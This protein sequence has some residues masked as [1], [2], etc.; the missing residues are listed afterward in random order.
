MLA[1]INWAYRVAVSYTRF[2]PMQ[3]LVI[4]LLALI[5]KF[6]ATLALFLPVKIILLVGNDRT[7]AYFPGF[8]TEMDRNTLI[9]ALCAATIGFYLL[10]ILTEKVMER[11]ES[12]AEKRLGNLIPSFL[13]TKTAME[14]V[15]KSYSR[16]SAGLAELLFFTVVMIF[17]A[18]AYPDLLLVIMA[19]SLL[20][21]GLFEFG[22]LTASRQKVGDEQGSNDEVEASRRIIWF[23]V[24]FLVSFIY[25][26]YD[27]L[28]G[29]GPGILI[30]FISF[31]LIRRSS[32]GLKRI[33]KDIGVLSA[34]R[35]VI[36]PLIFSESFEHSQ[37]SSSKR[38][39]MKKSE[40]QAFSERVLSK[41]LGD[42][43]ASPEVNWLELG[44]RDLMAYRLAL[45]DGGSE[46]TF[47]LTVYRNKRDHRPDRELSLRTLMPQLPAPE[48]IEYGTL[49][50]KVW[51]LS[52]WDDFIDVDSSETSD[53][54]L[55]ESLMSLPPPEPLIE[56]WQQAHPP[57]WQRIDEHFWEEMEKI[58]EML[59]PELLTKISVMKQARSQ[60][61]EM[62]QSLPLTMV[63]K[64]AEEASIKY[65]A[66]G[67]V[68]ALLW[69]KWT[70]EPLGAGWPVADDGLEVLE[71]VLER[72]QQVAEYLQSV[73]PRDIVL[74]ALFYAL[75][76]ALNQQRY[77]ETMQIF[78]L[79]SA[80]STKESMTTNCD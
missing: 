33:V 69:G 5:S 9:L 72:Q 77:A 59:A 34:Q 23:D 40:A 13:R 8:L 20:M 6:S 44:A 38:G 57:L 76:N 29:S 35:K 63:N 14:K 42:S 22:L 80:V 15:G 78:T 51:I 45:Q 10:H 61:V 53:R 58:A 27:L 56:E 47:L 70:I 7:P 54:L 52:A 24:G 32:G 68:V 30:A 64:D 48:L 39:F 66:Q 12:L 4:V 49:D 73:S 62:L 16:A 43:V 74:S 79:L 67:H 26:V 25:I 65:D 36:G 21:I 19:Y 55:V 46:R 41:V 17:I 50:G 2:L 60:W 71:R 28:T 3:T 75:E 31:L 18:F 11:V 37:A 1:S